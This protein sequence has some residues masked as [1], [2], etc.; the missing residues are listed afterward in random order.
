MSNVIRGEVYP[1]MLV[2]FYSWRCCKYCI[3]SFVCS[4]V[5]FLFVVNSRQRHAYNLTNLVEAPTGLSMPPVRLTVVVYELSN[6]VRRFFVHW[7]G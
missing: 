6:I 1:S 2:K 4:N 3:F 7:M 5:P